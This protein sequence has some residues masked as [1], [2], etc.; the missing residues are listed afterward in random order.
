MSIPWLSVIMPTYNGGAYLATALQSIAEEADSTIE[1]I[2]VDDGSTDNTIPIIDSFAGTIPIQLH[3]VERTGNWVANSN[4]ALSRAAGE[5][6]CFLHQDDYWLAN[7][8]QVVKE[9]VQRYPEADFLVSPACFVDQRGNISGRWRCPL[10]GPAGH[11]DS[12]LL[13][14][15]LL[16]QNFI[17]V[18]GPVFKR[19]AALA[20]GGLD[21][22]LWY[23]ADW[24]FWLKLAG[25]PTVYYPRPL[26]AFRVHAASQT[27]QR[28][29]R[30]DE[31][32]T[33]METVFHRHAGR[34]TARGRARKSI[35]DAALFSIQVNAALAA[36]VHGNGLPIGSLLLGFAKLGPM[37]G[38]HYLRDSRIFERISARLRA[39]SHSA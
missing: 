25:L 27:I 28:S 16:V 33:Q 23:T 6:A 19:K 20:A 17:A 14:N 37:G 13:L 38:W 22:S 21:E 15:R 39:R 2:V 34:I 29:F 10:P 18:P 8:L 12:G 7:R 26:V 24:D 4:V 5:Y 3:Q 35:E 36:C 32:R 30:T 1:C 31:F 9:L 11:V